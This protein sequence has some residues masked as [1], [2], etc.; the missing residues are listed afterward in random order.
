VICY[1]QTKVFELLH[2]LARKSGRH[3]T[4]RAEQQVRDTAGL[5]YTYLC[6]TAWNFYSKAVSFQPQQQPGRVAISSVEALF[7]R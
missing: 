1:Q 5:P 7:L 3:N 4:G 6:E 2:L